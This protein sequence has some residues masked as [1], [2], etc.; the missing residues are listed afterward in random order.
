[1]L[2]AA[3]PWSLPAHAQPADTQPATQPASTQPSDTGDTLTIEGM[4]ARISQLESAPGDDDAAR[5]KLIELY[6]NART[7]LQTV[8][9]LEAKAADLDKARLDAPAQLEVLKQRLA[10]RTTSQPASQP[11][12]QPS[13]APSDETQEPTSRP[14][15]DPSGKTLQKLEQ[16]LAT[17]EA[18]HKATQQAFAALG[19]ELKARDARLGAIPELI[20]GLRK[21]LDKVVAELDAPVD[22][23]TELT[24]AQRTSLLARKRAIEAE[25]RVCETEARS[26]EARR[27]VLSVSRD[28]ARL[29][30]RVANRRHNRFR[31]AVVAQRKS[32][33]EAQEE[34]ARRELQNAP[35]VVREL[36][37]RNL[38]LSQDRATLTDATTRVERDTNGVANT[39]KDVKDRFDA[40]QGQVST[41]GLTDEIGVLLRREKARLPDVR[42]YE[43]RIIA[44]KAE[45]TRLKLEQINLDAER[46]AITDIEAATRSRIAGMPPIED[47][48]QRSAMEQRIREM[49]TNQH[50]FIQSLVN[51]YNKYIDRLSALNTSEG[52]L[53]DLVEGIAQFIDENVLWIRSTGYIHT[54][55]LPADWMATLAA[56]WSTLV[57]TLLED[58]R[59]NKETYGVAAA[60]MLALILP[61]RRMNAGL[62][63]IAERTS[64][65]YE[66]RFRLTLWALLIT[67]FL[68]VFWPA[69]IYFFAWRLWSAMQAGPMDTAL[70]PADFYNLIESVSGALRRTS[71]IVLMF[72]VVRQVC[73]RRGLA[74]AHFRWRAEGARMLRV[75]LTAAMPILVPAVFVIWAC[76]GTPDNAWRDLVG[77]GAFVVAMIAL[78]VLLRHVLSPNGDL[79][80]GY[81]NRNK[82]SW[83]DDL[84]FVWYPASVGFP[85]VFAVAACLGYYY[86]A[87]QLEIRMALTL[88]LI[89]ALVLA[90]SLLVRYLVV[91][92]RRIAIEQVRVKREAEQAKGMEAP[93]AQGDA[94]LPPVASKGVDLAA[95]H[96]QT[97]SL[98][99]GLMMTLLLLGVYAIWVDIFPAFAFL[100]RIELW[101]HPTQIVE[102]IA[103]GTSVTKTK[104]VKITLSHIGIA[105]VVAI[106][107][108]VL[109]RNL[110]GLMEV[111]I[112][113]KLPLTNAGRYAITTVSR[114]LIAVIGI[115]AAFGAIGVGWSQ[116]QWL[117]AAIT[118]G[119]G[120]GL[121]EIF[122]NFVSGLIILFEQPIRPGDIVTVGDKTGMVS[123]IRI[124]ATTLIDPDR[125]ELIIP[126]KDFVTGR[127]L[128]WTLSDNI[129]RLV[130]PVGVAYGSDP[131]LV[132]SVLLSTVKGIP[133]ITDD[134]APM[135]LFNAFGANSLDFEL[136]LFV[137]TLDARLRVQH[138]INTRIVRS[139]A[140][141]RLEIPFPQRELHIRTS[142]PGGAFP[143]PTTS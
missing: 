101:A 70:P 44:R 23:P 9:T 123:R 97:R 109:S 100:N 92:Q 95:V 129:T 117:A 90:N 115:F 4:S 37:E 3:L 88:W 107:A 142:Q 114:Y 67:V 141:A 47:P 86:T 72:A 36:A 29:D 106:V 55:R 6:K 12:S 60:V 138:E 71:L 78:S 20:S 87:V 24:V 39:I 140:E 112:L 119:L 82:G 73:R 111:T 134:P 25:I 42:R 54:A 35:A 74:S 26:Y 31:R 128:N 139:F 46:V 132:E 84:K 133:E 45:S 59:R 120:F 19:D 122:A 32:D 124:R 17:A 34:F 108:F 121:Q 28:I 1:M 103:D 110:P 66:D 135:V 125:K 118:V 21:Q 11:A 58:A 96:T 99:T 43:R 5:A 91:A 75:S 80:G 131:A 83:I 130:F 116:V 126:N 89:L 143:P 18:E 30:M 105:L 98:L 81:L 102:T 69:I 22:S 62:A 63:A 16:D 52:E 76:E 68:A 53:I 51:T 41:I 14:V 65:V 38:K 93:P 7:Q 94:P 13:S 33:A 10:E 137:K 8:R 2:A 64:R 85:I 77:R 79:L 49:V 61:R 50:D 48:A 57:K 136:R 40:I 113:Q 15:A 127:I 27:E 56:G 104:V